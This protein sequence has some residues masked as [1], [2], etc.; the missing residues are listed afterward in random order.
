MRKIDIHTHI[1]PKDLPKFKDKYGYGGF[2]HLDHHAPCRARM[3]RDDGKFF[4][5]I[6]SNCW[7][8]KVRIAECDDLEVDMQVLSTVPVMFSYWTKEKDGND[9]ARFLNDHLASVVKEHPDR[10][11]GLGTLPM[12]S[13][14]LA[15]KELERCILEL[16]LHQGADRFACQRLESRCA[17]TFPFLSSGG[18]IG[19]GNFHPPL[20]ND[21]R[22]AHA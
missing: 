3:M 1:L 18:R 9:L 11:I 2:I 20:G 12:Q 14:D 6:E 13:P 7:D 4:R 8:A 5:E 16:G 17:G 22:V 21:G 15:I 10:F 19:R